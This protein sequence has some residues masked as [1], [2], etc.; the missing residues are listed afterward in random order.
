MLNHL[1]NHFNETTT[2]NGAFAY[3]STK[4][5]VL[6]LFSQGGAYRN[7]T[8]NEVAQLFSKAFAENPL[9]ALKTLFYLRDVKGGQGERRFFRV[10]LKHLALHNQEALR[11]NLHL[12]PEFGRWDDLWVLLDT[13]LKDDVAN[14][15]RIQLVKDKKSDNPSLL[16]KWMP[17]ENASSYT[18]KKYAKILREAYGVTP[19]QYRK[20]LSQLRKQ[21]SLV[22]TKL[23]EK[24]YGAIEYDKLPS[25]AGM[26]YRNAFLR[27]DNVRYTDFLDKLSSGE[28]KIN[29]STLYPYE[30]TSKA[31]GVYGYN[32]SEVQLLDGMWNNLPDY[33]GDNKENSIAVVD[34]SGSMSGR[35]MEVA[36]SIGLYLAE[37]NEGIFHNN[38]FTFSERPQLVTVKGTNIVEKV[39]NMRRADWGYST[40]IESV[41]NQ[42]LDVAVT[43]NVPQE[44]MIEKLYI[45][46]DMQF[47]QADGNAKA[48]LFKRLEKKYA[49]HG[50]KLPSLVFWNVD[51]RNDNTPFTMND[52]GVQLVSGFSPSI[53][54]T[55]MSGEVTTPYDLMLEVINSER[56][57]EVTV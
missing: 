48:H 24:N 41:F 23:T 18:T 28:K 56:Y 57:A 42:I 8:D 16:A 38:F 50:Y 17:S 27:N 51:A 47:N 45:I 6:D 19:K 20:L 13:R 33:I 4:S 10:A 1:Q 32:Q 49:Q 44:E 53:F 25:K 31:M 54:T 46:S 39:Q 29:S 14:L 15:V 52:F 37:R 3:K 36:I 12:V 9:L 30:I 55:L 22:E 5:D 21:I 26:I 7:R 43:Y 34:V 2:E 11:K 40:N 35:P